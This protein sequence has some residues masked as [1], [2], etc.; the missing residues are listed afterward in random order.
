M[1]ESSTTK[2]NTHEQVYTID[3]STRFLDFIQLKALLGLSCDRDWCGQVLAYLLSVDV[4][5]FRPEDNNQVVDD[6][7][8]E[9]TSM[10]FNAFNPTYV[11]IVKY[12]DQLT[13]TRGFPCSMARKCKPFVFDTELEFFT[14]LA[15]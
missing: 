1:N 2:Y 7:R 3:A 10:Q 11:W 12:H 4:R 13:S 8:E 9:E 15:I 6:G 5:H 14:D